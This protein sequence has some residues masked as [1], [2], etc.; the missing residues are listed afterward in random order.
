MKRT[1]EN[2]TIFILFIDNFKAINI[3]VFLHFL[4]LLLTLQEPVITYKLVLFTRQE[5][6]Q[7]SRTEYLR[8][9]DKCN[10]VKDTKSRGSKG[11]KRRPSS[12]FFFHFFIYFFIQ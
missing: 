7:K 8:Q 3:H 9:C 6:I 2:Y 1:S 5:V 10:D 4:S 12:A 11:G